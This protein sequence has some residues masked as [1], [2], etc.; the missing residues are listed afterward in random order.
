M[1]KS[2]NLYKP[3]EKT[4]KKQGKILQNIW[5]YI[6]IREWMFY[7]IVKHNI[8]RSVFRDCIPHFLQ[9]QFA[10]HGSFR[11]KKRSL[12]HVSESLSF[13]DEAHIIAS[14][15]ACDVFLIMAC[16]EGKV[17]FIAEIKFFLNDRPIAFCNSSFLAEP[18]NSED[19]E[20]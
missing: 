6:A 1:E 5:K 8:E 12:L 19:N 18:Q 20:P 15:A 4:A 13:P 7:N 11:E 3:K 14:R 2:G 10:V 9:C 17:A 16:E